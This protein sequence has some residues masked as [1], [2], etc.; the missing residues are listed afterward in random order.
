M[1]VFFFVRDVTYSNSVA[2]NRSSIPHIVLPAWGDTYDYAN[3][4]ECLNIGIFASKT[5]APGVRAEELGM[6]LVKVTGESEKAT[7][8]RASAKRLKEVCRA[9]GNGLEL[10]SVEILKAVGTM[11]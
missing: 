9:K 11:K 4:A 7:K 3:R 1:S 10:A 2:S 5:S 8:F 6:A